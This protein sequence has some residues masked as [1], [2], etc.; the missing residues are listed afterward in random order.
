VIGRAI[1]LA[2]LVA[3]A[4]GHASLQPG[5]S[6]AAARDGGPTGGSTPTTSS[7]SPSAQ[8]YRADLRVAHI[9]RT[10]AVIAE[11]SP[12]M[13]RQGLDYARTLSRGSCSGGAPRLRVECLVVAAERY[14]RDLGGA[15]A[16]RCPLYMDVLVSNV[17]ADERLIPPGTRYQIVQANADYRPALAAELRRIQ[18]RLAVDFRLA[19]GEARDRGDVAA[20]IDRYCLSSADETKFSYQTCVSSLVWFI[21]ESR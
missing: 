8:P 6:Q 9:E 19:T 5:R 20:K 13:L 16:T 7:A 21:E 1:A 18:G 14:C 10:L 4:D 3:T 15:E 12:A 17:L 11:A 2:A